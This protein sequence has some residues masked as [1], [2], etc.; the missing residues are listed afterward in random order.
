MFHWWYFKLLVTLQAAG[1]IYPEIPCDLAQ[2]NI[3]I[4]TFTLSFYRYPSRSSTPAAGNLASQTAVRRILRN[5][6]PASLYRPDCQLDY[7]RLAGRPACCT[8]HTAGSLLVGGDG[9]DGDMSNLCSGSA[10]SCVDGDYTTTRHR[11]RGDWW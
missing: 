4:L 9:G 11:V 10:D 7:Q 2:F 6:S 3:I 5:G 1:S 8:A